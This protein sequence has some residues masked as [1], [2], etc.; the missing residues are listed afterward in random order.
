MV[1]AIY[2]YP[3]NFMLTRLSLPK[4]ALFT[5]FGEQ[6]G[7]LFAWFE[8]DAGRDEEERLFTVYGTGCS[9]ADADAWRGTTQA[10]EYAW[11]L[12]EREAA[13]AQ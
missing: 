13:H 3:V 5:H 4:G 1:R 7:Q 10:S 2:K 12:Y 9:I 11:H 8:I 6:R